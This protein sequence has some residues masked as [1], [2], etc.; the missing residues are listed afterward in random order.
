MSKDLDIIRKLED[1]LDI[2]FKSKFSEQGG[3]NLEKTYTK[4]ELNY[5]KQII[6][7][8]INRL[9]LQEVPLEIVKLVNL[10]QLD[11]SGNQL[12][13]WS[14]EMAK[15]E[16]LQEL[17]L[18][19]NQLSVWPVEMANLVNLQR[20]DLSGNKLSAWPV[21]MANLGIK[22]Y[23]ENGFFTDKKK[24]IFLENNPLETPP[25][26]IIKQGNQA[27]IEYY[28]VGDTQQLN[29]VRVLFIGDGGAGKTSLIKRLLNQ[30]FDPTESQT[31]GININDWEIVDIIHCEIET[32]NNKIRTHL[33]NFGGQEIMHT[34]HQFFLSKRSLYIL[35]LDNRKDEKTEYWLKY[36]ESFGGDSPILIILNKIDENAGFDLDRK[37]LQEKYSSNPSCYQ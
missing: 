14:V 33:W 19:G 16:N 17:N 6:R 29:E 36:I 32:K 2:K 10:Q 5:E 13:T 11:L 7:L 1:K 28:Q 23:W 30:E 25:P 4:Y 34:T 8:W 3:F 35:V 24:G 31:K 21:K 12:S 37:T 18:A 27:I 26:E 22:T 20:L 15:L 9:E